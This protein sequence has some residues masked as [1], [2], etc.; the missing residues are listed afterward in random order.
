M[1]RNIALVL[2]IAAIPAT[3][4]AQ[5]TDLRSPSKV[6]EITPSGTVV[7][8]CN[9]GNCGPQSITV[10]A[11]PIAAPPEISITP[12]NKE[13]L[14]LLLGTGGAIIG[15][16][17]VCGL[18]HDRL[19]SVMNLHAAYIAVLS[20]HDTKTMKVRD[21]IIKLS[22]ENERQ[23]GLRRCREIEGAFTLFETTL[24]NPRIMK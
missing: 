3:A 18:P 23:L 24:R 1:I 17:I 10:P 12:H 16:S 4:A 5:S 22:A 11:A 6:I 15:Q 2:A 20:Q 14:A 19:V 7:Q 8:T 13:M 21:D 9:G